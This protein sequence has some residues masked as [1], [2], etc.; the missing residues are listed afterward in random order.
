MKL[1]ATTQSFP[2]ARPFAIARGSITHEQVIEVMIER[3]GVVGRGESTPVKYLGETASAGAASL[4]RHET[5]LLRQDLFDLD[6]SCKVCHTLGLPRGAAAAFDAAVHDWVGRRLGEPVWHMLG[7]ERAG[8]PTS[9]TLALDDV[10]GTLERL[11]TASR[12][13]VLKVKVGGSRDLERIRAIRERTAVPLRVD[14]NGGWDLDAALALLPTLAELGVELVEQPF[15]AD[16]D[17]AY[18][19]LRTHGSP[20]PIYADESCL[21]E[22]CVERIANLV[23][24]VVIKTAKTRGIQGALAQFKAATEYE[25]S[26]MLGCMVGSELGVA[27]GAQL[28]SLADHVDLDG[29]LLLRRSPYAG[30]ELDADGRVLPSRRPGLGVER[31][32]HV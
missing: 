5:K 9:F 12:F 30:L 29:H 1:R 15:P 24:G 26:T 11:E 8:P 22:R 19:A 7:L 32:R 28:I 2:L 21:D 6:R 20:L 23:D 31:T 27:A 17:D 16:E 3:D 25:L 13:R 10:A 14:A 4:R 18:R